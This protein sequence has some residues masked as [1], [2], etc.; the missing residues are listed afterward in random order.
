MGDHCTAVCMP[1]FQK[2]YKNTYFVYPIIILHNPSHANLQNSVLIKQLIQ[3]LSFHNRR[4][5]VHHI[6]S[7]NSNFN[8]YSSYILR[9]PQNFAKSSPYFW[10]AIHTR[11]KVRWRFC[12]IL[13]PSQ[14]IWTLIDES[15]KTG[16]SNENRAQNSIFHYKIIFWKIYL[17]KIFLVLL[18]SIRV[19]PF[20]SFVSPLFINQ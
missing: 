15:P 20:S 5:A 8:T 1:P 4:N 18:T 14:N 10:L 2:K 13:W 3:K 16:I 7:P 12:K 11:T 17:K 6:V 19:S 9:R